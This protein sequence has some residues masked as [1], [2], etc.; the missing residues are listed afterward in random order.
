MEITQDLINTLTRFETDLLKAF[1]DVR[2]NDDDNLPEVD[3]PLIEEEC[4]YCGS[5]KIIKNG[6]SAKGRQRY[7]CKECHKTFTAVSKSFFKNTRLSYTQWLK[8][9]D[10]EMMG[11]TLK[12]TSYQINIS[13]TSCF[14][15]RH[16][17]YQSLESI[18]AKTL[19]GEVQLD[20]A[21]INMDLKGLK[22]MPKPVKGSKKN[23]RKDYIFDKD[24]HICISTAADSKGSIL[25]RISGYGAESSIKYQKHIGYFDEKCK[26]ISDGSSSI[27]KFAKQNNFKCITLT[28]GYHKTKDGKHISDVNSL[29]SDLKNLIR[30]KRG[31][32]LKHL[33]GYLNWLVFKRLLAKI[34]RKL[35][36]LESYRFIK[37]KEKELI[38]SDICKKPFPIS[39]EE[40]YGKYHYGI[41][42]Y[43]HRS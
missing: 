21:F 18:Q 23:P 22:I 35:W 28:E 38:N 27:L 36:G 11:L 7:L 5:I 24:P 33:Q 20:T 6:F 30:N 2:N 42:Y 4:L 29:H 31:I 34:K 13:T 41:F 26:I 12:E 37:D 8:L 14:Y 43:Q 1:L 16:K 39:L 10:C 15:M 32:S 40:I 3:Q 19:K 9:L 25:F 17:L